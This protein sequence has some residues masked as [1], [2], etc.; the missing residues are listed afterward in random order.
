MTFFM[1]FFMV[2]S[3]LKN[4][5]YKHGMKGSK[6]KYSRISL[7]FTFE[8]QH[9]SSRAERVSNKQHPTSRVAVNVDR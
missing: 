7:A 6:D 1:T 4:N 2:P 3:I 9:T 5:E 8:I